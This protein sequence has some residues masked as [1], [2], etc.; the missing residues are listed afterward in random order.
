MFTR[1]AKYLVWKIEDSYHLFPRPF[2]VLMAGSFIDRVGAAL[3]FPFLSLYVTQKFHVGVIEVGK[4]FFIFA[5]ASFIGELLA[6]ALTDRFGRKVMIVFGLL[7][8]AIN[9]TLMGLVNDL[10]LFYAVAAVVG[11][12]ADMGGPARQAIIADLLPREKVADGYGMS[13]VVYNAAVVIGPVLGGVLAVTTGYFTLFLLD[14]IT[15]VIMAVIVVAALPETR[16]EAREDERRESFWQT[17]AGYRLVARDRLYMAF[18]GIALVIQVVYIQ[19]NTTLAVYLLNAHGITPDLFGIILS[20]NA[21]MVVLFQFGI[22][23][24]IARRPPL[25]MLALGAAL[26]GIGFALYGLVSTF[27]L[28]LV[29]MAIITLGEMVHV[30][31]QQAVVA[32]LAPEDMRGRYMAMMGFSWIIPFALGPLAAGAIMDSGA[33]NWVWYGGGLVCA[34]AVAACYGLHLIAGSRFQPG[35][36]GQPGEVVAPRE[37]LAAAA[38]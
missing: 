4:M 37:P 29:A 7:C 31:V 32:N 2:W 8:A 19:M 5:V 3:V 27:F 10:A 6:G 13:R 24:R 30:P 20:L 15:S 33:A 18:L 35:L 16:P 23:R 12:L 34:A 9:S 38:D 14:A 21:T 22:T 1:R 28:M 26:Y 25:L 11:M 17:L 36:A